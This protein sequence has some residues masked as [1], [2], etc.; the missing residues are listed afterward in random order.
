MFFTRE[1]ILKIHQ[2]LLKLGVK[3]SELPEAEP[4]NN[5]DTLSIVQNGKNKQIGV[6]DFFSQISLWKRED[7]INITD[8]YDEH[9]ISLIEAIKLVP[10]LQRKDGLVI[11]FQDI[12]GDWRIYQ[13]RG[14]ITEFFKEDK[15]TDLYDYT[16]YV[17]DS[18]IPDEEDLTVSKPDEHGNAVISLKDRIY[19]KSNFSG[20]G[21]KILRKNIKKFDIPTVSIVVSYAPTSSGDISITVND[22]VT[23]INLDSTTDTTPAIVAT[24]IAAALKS[25]LDDYDVSESSNRI[26]LTRHNDSS[27][28]PSSINVGN[29]SAVISVTDSVNK[30]VRKN[31]LTQ[32]MINVPNTIYEIRYDFDLNGKEVSV[33][34]NCVLKFEGGSITSNIKNGTLNGVNTKI[35]AGNYEI[36]KH[37]IIKFRTYK[38]GESVQYKRNVYNGVILTGTWDSDTICDNWTGLK[39]LSSGECC[40]NALNNYIKFC[41]KGN[42]TIPFGNYTYYGTTNLSYDCS[43]IDFC[44][45]IFSLSNDSSLIDYSIPI[46]EGYTDAGLIDLQWVFF[47]GGK[48]SILK[49]LT[50][51][52]KFTEGNTTLVGI[53]TSSLLEISSGS[54]NFTLENVTLKNAADCAIITHYRSENLTL[55]KVSFDTIGEHGIY[56]HTQGDVILNNCSFRNCN[57]NY[58]IHPNTVISA[59]IRATIRNLGSDAFTLKFVFNNCSFYKDNTAYS[60]SGQEISS[61]IKCLTIMN[62]GYMHEY[63]NCV[64]SGEGM[65]GIGSNKDVYNNIKKKVELIYNYCTNPPIVWSEASLFI[66]K[67]YNCKEVKCACFFDEVKDSEILWEYLDVN[68]ADIDD[69]VIRDIIIKNCTFVSSGTVNRTKITTC[70]NIYFYDCCFINGNV[71]FISPLIQYLPNKDGSIIHF[72]NCLFKENKRII[73]VPNTITY[74][75]NLEI[76]NCIA[77]DM[78]GGSTAVLSFENKNVSLV[79]TGFKDVK[80]HAYNPIN[81]LG[82]SSNW[83]IINM[84]SGNT[85]SRPVSLYRENVGYEYFDTSLNKNIYYIGD[86]KWIENDGATAGI[87]RHGPFADK[88]TNTKIYIGFQYFNT[89]THKIITWDGSKWWNPDGTEATS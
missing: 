22:K 49:N 19:D 56:L 76:I 21:Y 40:T 60:I 75:I 82:A 36:F 44:N 79:C 38:K 80:N 50:I 64:W 85:A 29:T 2:A 41:K 30:N 1:D 10:I 59:C 52:G 15:W 47:I 39:N 72:E 66:N 31:I 13:F 84:D 4:V 51:N 37:G 54:D 77:Y 57:Y 24:K 86:G 70:R 17:I 33:P 25:S 12:N 68:W 16:N 53:G 27:V 71:P 34:A 48:D 62:S 42:I 5:D 18:I 8:K 87:S 67:L 74:K 35:I 46:P 78:Y 6:R 28:S 83:T 81:K 45:S 9:Y 7:F 55:N 32:D 65:L 20:K 11:T 58:D 3:D 61:P 73:Q 23:N 14:N 69:N 89:D 63:N 43:T 88:P 26:T